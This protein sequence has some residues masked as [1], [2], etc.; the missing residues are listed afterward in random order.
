MS[1][2]RLQAAFCIAVLAL[3][4]ASGLRAAEAVKPPYDKAAIIRDLNIKDPDRNPYLTLDEWLKEAPKPPRGLSEERRAAFCRAWTTLWINTQPAGGKWWTH[5]I[6]APGDNYT[7]GIWIWD[8][9]FHILGLAHGGPKA[10]QLALWQIEVMLGGQ[11]E[12]GKVPR[13]VWRDGP[14][15]LGQYGIQA[16]GLLTLCAN[17]LLKVAKSD[18]ERAAVLKAMADFYPKFEKN[19]NWFF[20]NPTKTSIGLCIWSGWDS[21]WD[22]STRWDKPLLGAL[23]LD[24]FLY[25][26]RVEL[27][28]MARSLGKKDEARQWD[29]KAKELRD[30]I[31]QLHWSDKLG[32]YND[33]S[34]D[35]SVSDTLTPAIYWPMWAG[36]SKDSQIAKSID[37]LNDPKVFAAEWPVP[38]VPV[39]DKRF[40][41]KGYWRGPT[42][43]NLNWIT[44]RG[45]EHYG[46]KAEAA[47]LRDKTLDLVARTPVLY[48]YYDPITGEGVGSRNYGWTSALYVDLVLE[49]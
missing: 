30:Q 19:H 22:T 46:R 15:F 12:T 20:E 6:I 28:K 25:V 7:H 47:A 17:R 10:R 8:S 44:I 31:R 38:T 49:P 2:E 26:D 36:I 34:E 21:G 45:L 14:Q 40:E 48:E 32:I 43:I 1:I 9:A 3:T 35:K 24:C 11:H 16:P 18:E 42:W 39:T 33:V 23:D 5:P 41:P 4:G 29:A 37:Y 13:E 27:A